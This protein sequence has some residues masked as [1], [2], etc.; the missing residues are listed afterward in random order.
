MLLII[1][2]CF[3]NSLLSFTAVAVGGKKLYF[4]SHPFA[5]LK[6]CVLGEGV[7]SKHD[8]TQRGPVNKRDR[9]W[10]WGV[11]GSKTVISEWRNYWTAPNGRPLKIFAFLFLSFTSN[12]HV[13]LTFQSDIGPN[14][15]TFQDAR[16]K[17]GEI[18]LRSFD[19]RF[20]AS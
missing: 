1:G 13:S 12:S 7:C 15:K 2:C 8:A 4:F 17:K 11:G 5:I 19:T 14:L 18:W 16:C 6:C 3:K 9:A 10:W 20:F